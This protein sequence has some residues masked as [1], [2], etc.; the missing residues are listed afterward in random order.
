M[1]SDWVMW[2]IVLPCGSSSVGS[3]NSGTK[4]SIGLHPGRDQRCIRTF[5]ASCKRS[6]SLICEGAKDAGLWWVYA[7]VCD[8]L[9][10][11]KRYM[12]WWYQ[13]KSASN[14]DSSNG[15][16]WGL[17]SSL[18]SSQNEAVASLSIQSKP[19]LTLQSDSKLPNHGWPLRFY[20]HTSAITIKAQ[21]LS[22]CGLELESLEVRPP[23]PRPR[24]WPVNSSNS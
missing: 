8:L 22:S 13:N 17:E 15:P 14:G 20:V 1:K 10:N 19:D 5:A 9:T 3:M 18:M 2:W 6:R 16:I 21:T 7:L 24:V 12:N 4:P 11:D 23:L